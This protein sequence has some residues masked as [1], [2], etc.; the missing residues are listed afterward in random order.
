VSIFT[1]T[2][3]DTVAHRIWLA[4]WINQLGGEENL[5]AFVNEFL[6]TQKVNSLGKET[7]ATVDDSFR[8]FLLRN[9]FILSWSRLPKYFGDYKKVADDDIIPTYPNDAVFL[10][11]LMCF[12]DER[13][14]LDAP[15]LEFRKPEDAFTAAR[16]I[17][18]GLRGG[19][20]YAMYEHDIDT[21]LSDALFGGDL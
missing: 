18:D 6:L 1:D 20:L 11:L 21:S 4:E 14:N 16:L 10:L 8:P 13:G 7:L 15:G 17:R 9:R 19:R 5:D 12:A 3:K 2:F